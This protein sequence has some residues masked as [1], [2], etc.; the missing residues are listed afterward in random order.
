MLRTYLAVSIGAVALL[1]AQPGLAQLRDEMT[2]TR[3]NDTRRIDFPATPNGEQVLAVDTHTHTVFSDGVVWPIVRVWEAEQDHLAAYAVTDHLDYQRYRFDMRNWSDR[4]RAYKIATEEAERIGAR[5]L[6]IRGTEI[7]RNA[8]WGHFNALF[9]KDVNALP[10]DATM[11]LDPRPALRAARAQGAFLIWNHPWALPGLDAVADP[12]PPE[13]RGLVADGLVDA[14][15]IANSSQYS[16]PAFDMALKHDLAV[17]AA[18]DVHGPIDVDKQ[19]PEGQHRT[20]TLLI[21]KDGSAA[22]IQDAMTHKR[23]AA[24]YRQALYGRERELAEIVGGA[25]RVVGRKRVES[26]MTKDMVELELRNDAF[27]PFQIRFMT[28][29]PLTI[30]RVVTVPAHGGL[31]I[32]FAHVADIQT[33]APTVEVLNAF[34]DPRT[35]LVLTL[36]D[37]RQ[38][39]P[40]A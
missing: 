4:N 10:V 8:P 6:P 28:E 34:V 24:L 22:G 39:P 40:R 16:A 5:V 27:M 9:L 37:Q 12:M 20:V 32:Q 31:T 15:E 19:I 33:F 35:N 17:V 26:F 29:S 18:S 14:V 36:G 30:P 2:W 38:P 1:F 25:L 11:N 23:T 7:T 3:A 21:A 13:Q